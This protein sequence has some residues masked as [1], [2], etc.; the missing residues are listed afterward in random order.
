[1]LSINLVEDVMEDVMEANSTT[2]LSLL[3]VLFC[4]WSI[5]RQWIVLVCLVI[6]AE[7]PWE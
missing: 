6:V 5:G 3:L 4:W 1:M 2:N 7:H